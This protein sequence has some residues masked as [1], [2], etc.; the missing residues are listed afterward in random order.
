MQTQFIWIF[1]LLALLS[2]NNLAVAETNKT[3]KQ[4]IELGLVQ[5]GIIAKVHVKLG[6]SVK[7]GQ[8][9]LSL[10]QSKFNADIQI[11]TATIKHNQAHLQEAKREFERTKELHDQTLIASHEYELANN[12]YIAAQAA[13]EQARAQ[14]VKVQAILQETQ[15]IAPINGR[16]I[17]LNALPKQAVVNHC[18]IQPL[19]T[20]TQ[21]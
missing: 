1:Y 14:L 20:L 7:V 12:A 13:L 17:A 15:I 8:T 6:D 3:D 2:A 18:Q 16:V 21:E 11:A 19:I 9:L 4:G 5:S 10:E